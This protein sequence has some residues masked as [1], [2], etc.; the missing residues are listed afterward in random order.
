MM[1]SNSFVVMDRNLGATHAPSGITPP[2][3]GSDDLKDTYGLYYQWGRKDPFPAEFAAATPA[4]IYKFNGSGYVASTNSFAK[5]NQQTNKTVENAVKNPMTFHLASSPQEEGGIFNNNNFFSSYPSYSVNDD[6]NALENQCYSTMLHPDSMNSFWGYSAATGYGVTTTKTMYDPCPPG[7]I[8]AHYLV[9]TNTE[10][11]GSSSK[12]Y[13]SYLDTGWISHDIG[14]TDGFFT[15]KHK[16]LFDPAWYPFAGYLNGKDAA[17]YKRGYMGIIHTSTP[18]GNGSRS[19]AYNN[20]Y[21]GQIV[22]NSY[23]GLPSSFAYPVRCQK[24]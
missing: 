4:T 14:G 6:D 17:L 7:Y 23:R 8:V 5:E 13:Y 21:S 18:A 2:T 19:L 3:T 9:W 11:D 15:T 1:K 24:E 16:D 10:R 22:D 12:N 20:N